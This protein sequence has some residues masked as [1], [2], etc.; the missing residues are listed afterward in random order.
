MD[1]LTF[2]S[3]L[4][5]LIVVRAPQIQHQ[6]IGQ[7]VKPAPPSAAE[8]RQEFLAYLITTGPDGGP[9]GNDKI[10]RSR[11][12]MF[13]HRANGFLSDA[14]RRAPPAGVRRGDRAGAAILEQQRDTVGGLHDDGDFRVRSHD[15]VGLRS[16]DRFRIDRKLRHERDRITVNLF[17]AKHV[18]NAH[19]QARG[20][21]AP[22]GRT[23]A[24][25][26]LKLEIRGGKQVRRRHRRAA[27]RS[28]PRLLRPVE[29][30]VSL[31]HG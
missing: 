22:S 28:S 29:V 11:G 31:W 5:E 18:P 1:V 23:L 30:V 17:R 15:D 6:S 26:F 25:E 16:A 24:A 3:R 14:R 10:G 4:N 8:R 12:E 2:D 27:E 7:P 19:S 20:Q 9:D 21:L 13:F